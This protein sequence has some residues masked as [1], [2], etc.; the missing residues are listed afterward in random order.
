MCQVDKIKIY[1]PP[2]L[3][4]NYIKALKNIKKVWIYNPPRLN[5]NPLD[6]NFI[7]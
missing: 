3:N 4:K 2:R 5:K 7:K 1:N 6:N